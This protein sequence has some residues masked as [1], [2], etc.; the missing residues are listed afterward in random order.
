MVDVYR[1]PYIPFYLATREFFELAR[2]RLEPGG[3]VI[4]NVGHPEG[5]DDLEKVLERDDGRRCSRPSCATRARTPTRCCWR[6]RARS[7][8]T[9]S[10]ARCAIYPASSGA[11]AA[12]TAARIAPRLE[13][14]SVYT[15]DKAPVEW[16]I[17]QSIVEYAAGR[18]GTSG[19]RGAPAPDPLVE[20]QVADGADRRARVELAERVHRGPAQSS[21][22]S[23]G[24]SARPR[25]G[26]SGQGVSTT[27]AT[28]RPAARA[29]SS[30]SSEWLIVP[31]PGRATIRS[32]RPR[33]TARSRTR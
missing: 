2:D 32:G 31:R 8:R 7:R 15:D 13:G 3:V 6:R 12:R 17:D 23:R 5:Q 18:V 14:G 19:G 27:A 1:Q 33:S 9:G 20:R 29:A 24:S 16:L 22:S 25:P 4:V 28:S 10:S 11:P 21:R 30:D 26:S